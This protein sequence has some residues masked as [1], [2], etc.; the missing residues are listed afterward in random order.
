MLLGRGQAASPRCRLSACALQ[1]G[2][3]SASRMARIALSYRRADSAAISGRI[4]DRLTQRYGSGSVFMDIDEIPF[5]ID[6]RDHIAKVL[7][8]CDAVVAVIGPG[9]LGVGE[10]Q[11]RI[12]EATDPVR[13][14]V[15]AALDRRLPL[16]PV[17]VEGATM[18]GERDLP[19]SLKPLAYLNACPIDMGRDFHAHVD[20]L[21]RALDRVVGATDPPGPPD[22]PDPVVSAATKTPDLPPM[23]GTRSATLF[24]LLALPQ[25]VQFTQQSPLFVVAMLIS[26]IGTVI[27]LDR[28][29]HPIGARVV[30]AVLVI[31][32]AVFGQAAL[33][34]LRASLLTW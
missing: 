31:L 25:L 17:L 4:F 2:F 24:G 14:E 26:V 30:T 6:F 18:P 5:G 19:E 27:L 34:V 8:Q 3:R 28:D 33:G 16:I 10:G 22:R 11:R 20:R 29:D 32:V 21:I 9:W 13:A 7:A 15:Q 1:T 12:D 23:S